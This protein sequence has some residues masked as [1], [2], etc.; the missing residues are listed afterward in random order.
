MFMPQHLTR[1][2]LSATLCFPTFPKAQAASP[3]PDLAEKRITQFLKNYQ[4]AKN[5]ADYI[6]KIKPLLNFEE[7]VFLENKVVDKNAPLP[8]AVREGAH[9]IRFSHGE[10]SLTVQ[11]SSAKDL[12]LL[13][14]DRPFKISEFTN[15][16]DRWDKIQNLVNRA[17]SPPKMIYD[18]L[19]PKAEGAFFLLA[20]IAWTVLGFGATTALG[21]IGAGA[22]QCETL[23]PAWRAC[24]K[25]TRDMTRI[26]KARQARNGGK[27]PNCQ[28]RNVV[29][30]GTEAETVNGIPRE[31][32]NE[33]R[34]AIETARD[35]K[36]SWLTPASRLPAL[37]EQTVGESTQSVASL[38]DQCI[39]ILTAFS[40]QL[41]FTSEVRDNQD[42]NSDAIRA[43][44]PEMSP[45]TGP[46]SR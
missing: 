34:T 45:R 1:L 27:T 4:S 39:S 12:S 29:P 40:Q 20:P 6:E 5:F 33:V 37:C 16:E 11:I 42:V 24:E 41:C 2:I 44:N 14:N 18:A 3:A 19:I 13:V 43:L 21:S 15:L 8:K 10:K 17:G 22:Y 32:I 46:G 23:R 30:T 38:L 7:I 26:L 31:T 25:S 9:G 35:V 36:A 28:N